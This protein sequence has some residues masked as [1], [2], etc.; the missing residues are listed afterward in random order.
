MFMVLFGPHKQ[1]Q[2]HKLN[3]T[4]VAKSHSHS[5][6]EYPADSSEH[7][8]QCTVTM[9]ERALHNVHC[10]ARTD[11]KTFQ[12]KA[13]QA[14]S[15]VVRNRLRSLK[16]IYTREVQGKQHWLTIIHS[17]Y[18]MSLYVA[19]HST[20]CVSLYITIH[21]TYCMSLYVHKLT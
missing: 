17:T 15:A 2:F 3:N 10:G 7:F 21:S 12:N 4:L 14:M 1:Y 20:Y 13:S 16:A 18:C 5:F 9:C 6:Y 19:I 8:P 11:P